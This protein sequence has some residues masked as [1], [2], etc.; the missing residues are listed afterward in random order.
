MTDS[1]PGLFQHIDS[2]RRKSIGLIALAIALLGVV[3]AFFGQWQ[4]GTP[5]FG[6]GL[7]MIIGAVIG[8][9]AWKQGSNI[10]LI[11]AG[12]KEIEK[13]DDPVLVNVVEEMAIASGLPRP[14]IYIMPDE[15]L[16]AF[17]CGTSPDKAAVAVTT[18]LRRRLTR[19]ELQGV[20][21]HEMGHVGNYDTRVM[22]LLAVIVGTIAILADWMRR[23]IFY[24]SLGG[25]RSDRGGHPAMMIGAI[26]LAIIAP[27]AA[28]FIQFAVSRRREYLADATAAAMTRNP[29]A[30]ADALA[31]LANPPAPLESANHG[32]QHLF[33]VNPF[34]PRQEFSSP[35]ATHPPID[36]RIARLRKLAGQYA[37]PADLG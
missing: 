16:N 17:A 37:Q 26:A 5:W 4:A 15:S 8:F 19:D 25:R 9:I 13:Q 20:V 22:I 32:T 10:V 3:G 2:N 23:S 21:A 35:F 12:A 24:S 31:K 18:G 29:G 27:M 14:R 7:A 6:L 30:L 28:L 11:T 36:E 33:I 1:G 34:K